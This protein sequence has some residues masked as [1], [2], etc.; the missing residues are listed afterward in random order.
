[1]NYRKMT[2]RSRHEPRRSIGMAGS[3][4]KR[5]T[6]PW[7][8]F[9]EAAVCALMA[10]LVLLPLSPAVQRFPF[11]DSG[12]FL[13]AGWRLGEGEAPYSGVWDHKPPLIYFLNAAGLA[14]GNGSVWG[15]WALEWAFLSAAC[16]L[17]FRLLRKT[18]D[19]WAAGI[20][21]ILMIGVFPILVI[22]GN[23]ATEYALPF[24]FAC[25]TLLAG[26]RTDRTD[27]PRAFGI[28]LSAA[29]LFL[30]KQNLVGIPA[31]VLIFRLTAL[32]R[33]NQKKSMLPE[34]GA[35]LLGSAMVI[36]PVLGYF[37]AHG[38]LADLWD[39]AFRFNLYYAETGLSAGLKSLFHGLESVSQAGFGILGLAG[40]CAGVWLWTRRTEN[41]YRNHAWLA[42]AFIALPLEFL[43]AALPG[44]FEIHYYL[45]VLPALCVFTS[46]A[47]WGVFRGTS[48]YE[49]SLRMRFASAG[50]LLV[51]LLSTSAT[52]MLNR[53]GSYR[54]NDWSDVAAFIESHS[55]PSDSVLFWGAEAGL[56]FSTKRQSPTRY[57]YL[58]PL[59]R[60][61][62]VR[63]EDI[64]NF[65]A[66]LQTDPPLWIVDTKNPMT[67]FLDL[68]AD[69]AETAA[70]RKWFEENYSR[71]DEIHGWTFY[72]W[73]G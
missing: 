41:V 60:S 39:A 4:T 63:D 70:F 28:G 65:Y 56:N 25:F 10:A 17:A 55:T 51:L 44:R 48:F 19:A 61:G 46:L 29:C 69:P 14:L 12:V 58:Y 49:S 66:S 54:T 13:Y 1:M 2:R 23:L 27:F 30:L 73:N 7:M 50:L 43:L 64:L 24:Q 35:A 72:R 40:W 20:S 21:L 68:P 34:A 5:K 37:A 3:E 16:L 62:Y 31:V 38:A 26:M 22:G 15:V 33:K 47:L 57:A 59:Y 11:R 71:T 36:L 18:F 53:I 32:W 42:A 6:I 52:A 8:P 67:P 45:S 9:L